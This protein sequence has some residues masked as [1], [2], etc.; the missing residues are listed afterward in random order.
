MKRRHILIIDNYDSFTFNLYHL[1]F[2]V[3]NTYHY[4]V[5]RNRDESLLGIH[6]DALVISPGPMGPENTGLLRE[7][8]HTVVIPRKIP[9]FGV[10]LGMQ[11]IASFFGAT[12]TRSADPVHGRQVVITHNGSDIFSGIGKEIMVMR[13]NSLDVKNPLPDHL[14]VLA[15]QKH[16]AMIMAIRHNIYPFVGVQFHP[17][18]FLSE[19]SYE[20]IDNFFRRYVEYNDN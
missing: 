3:R 16:T 1:L 18:S 8:F 12:V 11:C 7:V 15:R 17:E 14:L 2:G 13:Y 19:N 20:L 4:S 10:C 9:V 5:L 6:F